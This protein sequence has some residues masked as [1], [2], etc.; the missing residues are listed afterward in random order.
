MAEKK[1]RCAVIGAGWWG[2]AAH[3]PSFYHNRDAELVAIQHKDL[4]TAERIAYDFRVPNACTTTEQVLAIE[5]LDAVA[6]SSPPH[7]HYPQAKAALERG[8][9]VLVEKPMTHTLAQTEELVELAAAQ[10]RELVVGCTFHY[11]RHAIIAKDLIQSGRLGEIKLICSLFMDEN[12]GLYTG[13]PWAEFAADHPDPEVNAD[14]Y[15]APGQD[16]YSD[17]VVAGG[18]QLSN[19]V[20]HPAALLSF[21]TGQRPVEVHGM[22]ASAGSAKVDVFDA[23]TIKM[24]GGT[25]VSLGSGGWIR[26]A[27]RHLDVRVYGTKGVIELELLIGK[28]QHW[29]FS[30]ETTAYP[31]LVTDEQLYPRFDPAKNLVEV[32]LGTGPNRSPGLFALDAMRIVEGVI[33]S[34]RD[35]RVVVYS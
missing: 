7:L 34:Q 4:A 15:V 1:A 12:M 2:T 19:Q 9:H 26:N 13:T 29:D 16:T 32:A 30:G 8:L 5:E 3:V 33:V 11:N 22:T 24:N 17:P 23:M 14:A 25:M 10:Q 21:L 20:S 18:G 27:P 35:Q 31:D 28:L 6:I